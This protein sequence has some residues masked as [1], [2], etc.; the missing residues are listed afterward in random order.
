MESYD[1]AEICELIG[2]SILSILG[3]VDELQ[4]VGLYRDDGLACLYKFSGPVS[5]KTPNEIIRTFRENFGFKIIITTNLKIFNP[6]DVHSI[7]ASE[8][9]NLIRTP[10]THLPIPMLNQTIHLI[11]SRHYHTAFKKE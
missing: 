3:K 6:L 7:Y 1:G 11:S 8:V 9:A 10:T 4:N 5:E 2:L